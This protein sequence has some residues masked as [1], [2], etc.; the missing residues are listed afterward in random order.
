MKSIHN[1][2]GKNETLERLARLTHGSRGRW[3]KMNVGQM[4]CHCADQ[5]RI[6]MGTKPA[7]KKGNIL[8]QTITR[9]VALNFVSAMP[10]NMKT[11]YELNPEK[12]AM[13][14]PT[15]FLRDRDELIGLIEHFYS[16]PSSQAFS[17]PVFGKLNKSQLG[18]L[19][20]IH[21]DHHLQQFGV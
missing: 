5:L 21:L 12:G 20:Y 9:F 19:T 3:G 10:K 16:L 7:R 15:D 17:H 8:T 2:D 14:Q 18:R 11:I 6:C 1:L 13:T 4:I